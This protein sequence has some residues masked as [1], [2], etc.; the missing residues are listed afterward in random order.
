M[1]T[2]PHS[3]VTDYSLFRKG[4]QF[5][6][7]LTDLS[8]TLALNVKSFI[9]DR[10]SERDRL[11]GQADLQQRLAVPKSSPAIVEKPRLPP[12]PPHS[13]PSLDSS[14]ASMSLQ[15]SK[16]VV[17]PPPKLPQASY[18]PVFPPPPHQL[19]KAHPNL[20][21]PPPPLPVHSAYTNQTSSNP[22]RDPY[23]D[24]GMF[25]SNFSSPR[26]A[27]P[28][29]LQ[30]TPPHRQSSLSMPPPPTS[31]PQYAANPQTY[32]QQAPPPPSWGYYSPQTQSTP[33]QGSQ[34]Q[35]T[36]LPP[37]PSQGQ[38]TQ[39]YYQGYGR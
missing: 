33:P 1:C 8:A 26:V 6:H 21:P 38:N 24:L 4:L 27:P 18:S 7:Q 16:N 15:G 32:G 22:P 14:F 23:A 31:R 3:I 37:P 34:Y 25:G 2:F 11:A 12:P 9:A 36:P 5:Y 30:Q 35:T 20:P 39:Q 19:P 10:R 17:S 13:P 29:P 28:V